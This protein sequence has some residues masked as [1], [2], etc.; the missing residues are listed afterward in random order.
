MENKI[1]SQTFTIIVRLTILPNLSLNFYLFLTLWVS[2]FHDPL[3]RRA[4]G[5]STAPTELTV[6]SPQTNKQIDI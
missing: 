5:K 4:L 2:Q 6:R 3:P 1:S